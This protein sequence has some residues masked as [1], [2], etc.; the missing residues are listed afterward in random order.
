ERY[1]K[2]YHIQSKGLNPRW[3]ITLIW[4]GGLAIAILT[5]FHFR[6]ARFFTHERLVGCRLAYAVDG[7]PFFERHYNFLLVVLLGCGVPLTITGFN[8]WKVV[9]KIR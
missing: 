9:Q 5:M 1:V 8:Y 3:S 2:L 4:I 7:I 6:V